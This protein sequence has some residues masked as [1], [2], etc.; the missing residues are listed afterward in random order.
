MRE[1]PVKIKLPTTAVTRAGEKVV[2]VRCGS[3]KGS[4]FAIAQDLVLTCALILSRSSACFCS[5]VLHVNISCV[6]ASRRS[7]GALRQT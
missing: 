6:S 5:I 3:K 4:G 2:H 7:E 1:V